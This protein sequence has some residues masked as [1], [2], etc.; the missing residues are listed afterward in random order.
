[1]TIQFLSIS[2]DLSVWSLSCS[3]LYNISCHLL[4]FLYNILS[5][6]I[7]F[8]FSDSSA[9]LLCNAS[10][11]V[12][13][14]FQSI[15]SHFVFVLLVTSVVILID[16]C[17]W[18]NILIKLFVLFFITF[19]MSRPNVLIF[20]PYNSVTHSLLLCWNAADHHNEVSSLSTWVI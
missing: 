11:F 12:C 5:D 14:N 13:T 16:W 7:Q 18:L 9:I 6:D 3:V 10:T 2:S 1:M 4:L 15:A 17:W 8:L 19:A 20:F